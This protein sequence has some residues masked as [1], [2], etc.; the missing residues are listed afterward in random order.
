M[1][2]LDFIPIINWLIFVI[3]LVFEFKNKKAASTRE[4]N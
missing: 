4:S 3:Q 2:L 1:N